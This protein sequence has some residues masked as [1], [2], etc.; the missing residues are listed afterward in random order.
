M[1]SVSYPVAFRRRKRRDAE[2]LG[3]EMRARK[4]LMGRL[5]TGLLDSDASLVKN[6]QVETTTLGLF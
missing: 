3:K 1:V 2:D 5:G 6:I 4:G